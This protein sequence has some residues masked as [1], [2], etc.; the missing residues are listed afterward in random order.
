MTS[1]RNDTLRLDYSYPSN[2]VDASPIV[3]P[4]FEASVGHNTAAAEATKCISLPFSRMGSG[5]GQVGV[6]LLV[7]ADASCMKKKFNAQSVTDLTE[8][9]AKGIAASGGHANFGKAVNFELAKRP[10]SLLQGSFTLPTGQAMQSLVV[11]VLDPPDIAC[12]QFLS[13]T[14]AGLSTMSSFPVTFE[15]SPAT[16]LVPANLLPNH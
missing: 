9:E 1:Y 5:T 14:T 8:G 12:F 16:P 2:Y 10:A 11:C 7:R 15:G 4:A 6:L 3:G 13:N